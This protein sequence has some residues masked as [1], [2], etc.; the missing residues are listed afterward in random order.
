[1]S[2]SSQT[3]FDS[4]LINVEIVFPTTP[5]QY[6]HLL[7]RQMLRNHR[8]PCI[9]FSPKSLLRHPECTS[10]LSE[11]VEGTKFQKVLLDLPQSR[12]VKKLI[13]CTGKH[14]YTLKEH[15]NANKIDNVAIVRIEEL[16]P[17]PG[18]D[19]KQILEKFG[20]VKEVVWSQ[21]EHRNMGAWNFVNTRVKNLF[22]I[23]VGSFTEFI[24]LNFKRSDLPKTF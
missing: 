5:S 20:H 12:S 21:E 24:E 18:L 17:F 3:Q 16:S 1:M 10:E 15:M 9:V 2:N 13:L 23:N 14:Y 22:N 4:D 11:F 8:K 7:R 6:F 19:L